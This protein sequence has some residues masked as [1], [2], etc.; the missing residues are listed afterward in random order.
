MRL[1]IVIGIVIL[2]LARQWR[3]LLILLAVPLYYL[4]SH[5]PFGIDY[6]Y[7]MPIHYFLFIFVAVAFYCTGIAVAQV[8]R[9]AKLSKQPANNA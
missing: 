9:R 6:R 3:A 7:I 2:G 4:F 1:L 5:A 8:T